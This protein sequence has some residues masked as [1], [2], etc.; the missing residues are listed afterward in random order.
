M[1]RPLQSVLICGGT[2]S[3][4]VT[5]LEL[6]HGR[7]TKTCEICGKTIVGLDAADLMMKYR[8]HMLAHRSGVPRSDGPKLPEDRFK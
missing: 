8:A 7:F 4:P 6:P 5:G 1:S 3:S 2:A